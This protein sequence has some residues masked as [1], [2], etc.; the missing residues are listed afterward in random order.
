MPFYVY[1]DRDTGEKYELM[2]TISEMMRRQKS[3]GT[4]RHDGKTLHRNV[5][6]EHRGMTSNPGNWPMKSDAA[7]VHPTQVGAAYTESVKLGVPTRFDPQ[8]GQA[9]FESR[10]HRKDFLKAKGMFDR[11]GG[12]GD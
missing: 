4:I 9:I 5:A 3:D 11:S 2:M 7:G 12:Y 10:S 8:T 6:A 1:S